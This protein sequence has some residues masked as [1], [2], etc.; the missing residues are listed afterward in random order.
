MDFLENIN[1]P[2]WSEQKGN[3]SMNMEEFGNVIN[4]LAHKSP[5]FLRSMSCFRGLLF[6]CNL[7]YFQTKNKNKTPCY[8]IKTQMKGLGLRNR[9]T[10]SHVWGPMLDPSSEGEGGRTLGRNWNRPPWRSAVPDLLLMARSV[11]FFLE[12]RT[13]SPGKAPST[14][15]WVFL[16]QSSLKKMSHGFAY[17]FYRGIFSKFLFSEDTSLC[18]V[19]KK[20][21]IRN[22]NKNM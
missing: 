12:P 6:Q 9:V 14:M 15:G 7:S 18:Q 8:N 2:K 10:V 16:H 4:K 21:I 13:T 11:C 3:R 17:M 1:C 5:Q 20:L 19:D 22:G